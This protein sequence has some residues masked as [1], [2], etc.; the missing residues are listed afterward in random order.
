MHVL[1]F[2]GSSVANAENIKK[3]VQIVTQNNYPSQIVVVSA[4]RGVTDKLIDLGVKAHQSEKAYE[5]LLQSL[6]DQ[7]IE[8][9]N[10][11]LPV[12]T[13]SS[14]LSMIMQQFNELEDICQSVFRL[15]ELSPA[16][17][18]RIVS[19]GELLSSKII[20][21]Y[22]AS[23]EVSNIW[24]DSRELILTNDHFGYAAVDFEK[25]NEKVIEFLKN[26]SSK[27]YIAPGFI[28][29]GYSGHITTLGRGGSDYT[30]AIY[31]AAVSAD[32]LEIW[33]DV[34]GMMT[35]DPRWVTNAKP[36]PQISYKEAMELSHFGAKVV[37]PPTILP[38]MQKEIPVLVKNTFAPEDK[39]T[40]MNATT[41]H[42]SNI[43][44]GIS[45]IT[46]VSLLSLEGA[47]MVGIPGF[48]K[49]L[50]E[51][52]A[53]ANI[54]VILITQGSSEYSICVVVNA[55]DAKVASAAVNKAF[56][57]E[58]ANHKVE[59]VHA[60][61]NLSIV[62]LVGDKMKSHPNVSGRMFA[63]LGRNGINVRA[64]AQGSSEKNIS[65]VIS[66]N[67]VKKAVNVLHEVFFEAVYKQ[68]NV[69]VI[70]T[71][72][73]GSR[74][75]S[76]IKQ[77]HS[78]LYKHLGVNV[79]VVGLANSKKMYS[80]YEQS[81]IDLGHWEK[82]LNDDGQEFN[83][84]A[85][86]N[87]AI[88]RNLRNSV[89]VDVTANEEV[90][91]TY[92]RLLSKSVAV[93]ACNKIAASAS[94]SYYET[95]KTLSHEFNAPFLFE[96]NVGAGLPVIGTLNDL[97][98]SGDK[99]N[100]IQ[101]VLSGTL[102]YVFNNYD[103]TKPF[104]EVVRQAQAE[105]YTE[106]DPRLDLGGTDVMRK[107][108]ILAREA[109]ST[110]EMSDVKNEP[111]LPASCFEGSVEDFYIEMGKHEAHFKALY[112]AAQA[113]NCKLKFVAEFVDGK[114]SVGLQQVSG[115]SDF[116]HLYGKDN[117]VLFYTMRYPDQ[118]LV[119]KGAGAGAEVTASGVFADLMKAG[120]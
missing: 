82:H 2:G 55:I 49:T 59:P 61:N 106:P 101:A 14:C 51:A 60:E 46:E 67:D 36:I 11:L 88:E 87:G 52:L 110:I 102:N 98:R 95:L 41:T 92:K 19:F 6:L 84:D 117:I 32:V 78:Y 73:V 18:D 108:M 90:A 79:R 44:S 89:V 30:A 3:V 86:V 119:V 28:A 42:D 112:D 99:V 45:S 40:L 17:K 12:A 111:F 43:V 31:A 94:Y 29:K 96:T 24:L 10:Q 91:K 27:L 107:I 48:S 77:Q 9:A 15:Q 34:S 76:Q 116:F 47:G 16:T 23:V 64:I 120:S 21:A 4:M 97:V 56:E 26:H 69:Y 114:A 53:N 68:L 66:V 35:A 103:G 37:Y 100:K 8:A 72:N 39:G 58:I 104:A 113:N 7:H 83:L 71:G 81:G 38:V 5:D 20:S 63:T 57:N 62:A 109:G 85:F 1:K 75:L 22:L 74:L 80:S 65:A 50:F 115:Q 118:P 33:T 25:T 13:R 70:G 105:G 93:V 54:N